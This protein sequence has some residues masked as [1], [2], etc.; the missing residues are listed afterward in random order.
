MAVGNPRQ[1]AYSSSASKRPLRSQRR[2]IPEPCLVGLRR[3]FV[4]QIPAS[5]RPKQAGSL[6]HPS[7]G[8][9]HE[10]LR[11][12][13]AVETNPNP[14][15]FTKGERNPRWHRV[16]S[17]N[18]GPTQVRSRSPLPA[19]SG[20]RFKVKGASDCILT[21]RE[22]ELRTRAKTTSDS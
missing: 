13:H 8:K 11:S 18:R 15:P 22:A 19:R 17:P 2:I 14:L 4:V 21:A 1:S 10:I 3:S 5:Y 16:G 20:E 9:R 6:L 12:S 7:E